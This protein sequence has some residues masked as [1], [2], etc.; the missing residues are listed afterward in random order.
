MK[1]LDPLED[2]YQLIH[3]AIVDDPP[4]SQEKAVS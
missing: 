1:K 2:I 4:I 3:S